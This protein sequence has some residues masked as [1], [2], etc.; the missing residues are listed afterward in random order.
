MTT[1]L[2]M[3]KMNNRQ[4]RRKLMDIIQ[5]KSELNFSFAN[6][7]E[8]LSKLEEIYSCYGYKP[9]IK[10]DGDIIHIHIDSHILDATQSVFDKACELCNRREYA[11]S[12]PLFEDVV[13]TCPLHVDAYR[14]MAQAYMMLGDLDKAMDNNI[15]ALRIDA[16]N[17]WALV[18]MGNIMTRKNDTETAMSYYNKVLKYHPDDFMALNNVGA[19][20]LEQE[21][22]DKAI[23]V[24]EKCLKI[25]KS[26]M[27]SYYGMA[28][29]YYHTNKY[30]EAL[31][32]AFEGISQSIDRK[33]NPQVREE[34][35]KLTI[36]CAKNV[37]DNTNF[38]HLVA[39]V[40]NEL[41]QEF[42]ADIRMESDSTLNLSAL[43]QYGKAHRRDYHLIKYNDSKK[44][45]EHHMLHEL[46]HLRMN[47]AASREGTNKLLGYNETCKKKFIARY[48]KY[49]SNLSAKFS[50]EKVD[51]FIESMFRGIS[52]QL[53][54]CPLDLLVE[55][56]IFNN[57]PEAR[58]L[59]LLSLFEQEQENIQAIESGMKN[60]GMF[61][62]QI[63]RIS[64]IMNLVTSLH[65]KEL[66]GLNF[67]NYYKPTKQDLKDAEDLYEEYKAYRADYKPGEEYDM[68]MYFIEQLDSEEFFEIFDE[69]E[70][71]PFNKEELIGKSDLTES[72][73]LE[74]TRDF[75]EEHKDGENPTET[76][77]M[78]MYMFGAMEYFEKKS[79]DVIKRIALEIAMLGC[80][81]ISPQQK[82][83]YKV[84]SIPEKDFGGYLLL[85]YYYVSWAIAMPDKLDALQLPFKTAYES[86]LQMYNAKKN[87]P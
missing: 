59:Q 4:T 13:K 30:K 79:P 57:Y 53:M 80:G 61:P 52:L 65:F 54:N 36:T 87:K 69:V 21:K 39:K 45:N 12:I 14:S 22:Y 37:V 38:M 6:D 25:E 51:G 71:N 27:N 72:E 58:P 43:L 16:A 28:L 55:D 62:N 81:G 73:K 24:F 40:K 7:N 56:L 11:K 5:F 42:D 82:S 3:M 34:L 68:V 63:L 29:A 33:E 70:A 46:M 26:Y 64:K 19:A 8:L 10:I 66:F 85:A 2:G 47:L 44:Y 20:L 83:G 15:E 60:P 32:I 76:F 84:A 23:E 50:K 17:L 74:I 41:A 78:S 86:A 67:L 9:T 18:L 48:S 75:N 35:L 49:F 1:S 77:M 31:D